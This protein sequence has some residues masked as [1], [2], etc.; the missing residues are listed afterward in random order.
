MKQAGFSLVE[1]MVG[2]AILVAMSAIGIPSF[3]NSIGNGQIKTV[4]ESIKNGLQLSR[5]EA[6]KRNTKIKFTLS[7][8]SAWSY[9]CNTITNDCPATIESKNANEGSSSNIA[10]TITSGNSVIFNSFGLR[11]SASTIT[12]VEVKNTGMTDA[13]QRELRVTVNTGGNAKICDPDTS[14]PTGDP[15]KC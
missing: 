5:L 13:E 7:T 10:L 15:R 2:V 1:L 11:D 4:A 9:G 14:I 8:N 12:Q 6:I 3:K